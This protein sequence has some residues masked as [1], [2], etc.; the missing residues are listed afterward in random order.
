MGHCS[1]PS[2]ARHWRWENHPFLCVVTLMGS[3]GWRLGQLFLFLFYILGNCD[4]GR[5]QDFFE[6]T[7]LECGGWGTDVLQPSL[8]WSQMGCWTP[9]AVSPTVSTW[10]SRV[11]FSAEERRSGTTL[12]FKIS[13]L[14][15]KLHI[16]KPSFPW[17]F[18]VHLTILIFF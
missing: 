3:W 9:G 14:L 8:T 11:L 6:S 16:E 4:W 12:V 1:S 13:I 10:V 17:G 18:K 5:S 2:S 7:E 15:L